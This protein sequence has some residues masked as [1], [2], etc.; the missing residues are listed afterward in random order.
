MYRINGNLHKVTFWVLAQLVHDPA[1][2]ATIRAESA[3][4]VINNV[5]NVGYLTEQC[6][7]LESIFYEVLRMQTS[8][9]LMRFVTAPTVIGGKFLRPGN[10]V[11]APYRQLHYNT[12]VWGRDAATFNPDRFFNDKS[13][14]RNPSFRPFGGGVNLCPGRYLAW[15]VVST[16]IA[17]TLSRF[18][19][20]LVGGKNQP[21]PRAD[22]N[23]PAIATMSPTP[24]SGMTLR[25]TP[26]Y[27]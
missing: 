14:S 10:H 11:M 16:F 13:L 22:L 2:L 6:P 19:I 1:L 18:E 21:I 25:L 27:K 15:K 9:S 26:R 20:E 24:G 17:L 4:G 8:S 7:R 5:P 3:P 12:A 23:T